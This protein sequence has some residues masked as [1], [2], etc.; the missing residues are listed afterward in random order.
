[1]LEVSVC[2]EQLEV[3]GDAQ[4]RDERVDGAELYPSTATRIAEVGCRDVVIARRLHGGERAEAPAN[5]GL[6]ALLQKTLK[7]FLNDEAR[8][9]D[10]V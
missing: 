2:A 7:K 4:L 10:Q 3:V 5:L 1:M 8:R 9:H 6:A